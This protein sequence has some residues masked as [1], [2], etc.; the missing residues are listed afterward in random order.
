MQ[1]HINVCCTLQSHYLHSAHTLIINK[2]QRLTVSGNVHTVQ[3]TINW[4]NLHRFYGLTIISHMLFIINDD[5]LGIPLY[6]VSRAEHM[7][8]TVKWGCMVKNIMLVRITFVVLTPAIS[9]SEY[10]E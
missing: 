7:R 3:T 4:A 9:E 1:D 5:R 2:L 6:R 10:G 8:R